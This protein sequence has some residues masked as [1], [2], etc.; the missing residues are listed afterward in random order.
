M[1]VS[2]AQVIGD[3]CENSNGGNAS[4]DYVDQK[5]RKEGGLSS[6]VIHLVKGN[7]GLSLRRN[8]GQEV[9]S[10]SS[11]GEGGSQSCVSGKDLESFVKS[12][13]LWVGFPTLPG[14]FAK[15]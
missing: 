15:N 10:G 7:P 14:F 6:W 4:F 1:Y 12:V 5:A 2:L 3:T 13:W 8:A 9:M 11:T